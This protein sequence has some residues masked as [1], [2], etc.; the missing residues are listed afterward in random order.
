MTYDPTASL[1][2]PA[3]LTSAVV[4]AKPEV[5]YAGA[6]KIQTTVLTTNYYEVPCTTKIEQGGNIELN[7]PGTNCFVNMSQSYLAMIVRIVKA[8]GSAIADWNAGTGAANKVADD[9]ACCSI[10]QYTGATMWKAVTME[11]EGRRVTKPHNW[12]SHCAY[13][14]ALMA[15]NGEYKRTRLSTA[16]W[17]GKNKDVSWTYGDPDI[18]EQNKVPAR[19]ARYQGAGARVQ[20]TAPLHVNVCNQPLALPPN[21]R[22]RITLTPQTDAFVLMCATVTKLQPQTQ[23]RTLRPQPLQTASRTQSPPRHATANS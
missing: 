23:L 6:E 19:G 12:Y 9:S 18:T 17:D 5:E 20:R 13:L 7:Y 2:V 14:D 22:M 11:I 10:I 8:D 4:T 15:F 1:G 21:L 16:G 3:P